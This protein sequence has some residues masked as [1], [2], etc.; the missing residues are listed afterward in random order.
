MP[1][2]V[3]SWIEKT[4][5]EFK[6]QLPTAAGRATLQNP[7]QYLTLLKTIKFLE[8]EGLKRGT[9]ITIV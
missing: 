5:L 7:Q 3:Q 8:R 2:L 4:L 1:T 9:N 6:S